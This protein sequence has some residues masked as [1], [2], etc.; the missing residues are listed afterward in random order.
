MISLFF[1]IND[2][3][4]YNDCII[5]LYSKKTRKSRVFPLYAMGMELKWHKKAA[6]SYEKRIKLPADL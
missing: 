4:I 2:L 6:A 1:K 3:S 5:T